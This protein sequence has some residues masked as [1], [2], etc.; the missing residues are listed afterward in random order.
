M[1]EILI[2]AAVDDERAAHA[3]V[4]AGADRLELCG[5]LSV[6]GVTPPPD[7]LARIPAFGVP[8]AVMIRCRGGAFTVSADERRRMVADARAAADAGAAALVL[9]ALDAAGGLDPAPFLAVADAVPGV[10]LV[11]HKAID[12]AADVDAAIDVLLGLPVARV[13]TSGG[14][15]TAWDG[16]ARLAALV[17]RV[18]DRLEILPGGRV[19]ADR[20]AALVRH[21]GVAQLHADGRDASVIAALRAVRYFPA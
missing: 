2:E 18:G 20:A 10:P 17:A 5:D 3:A 16:R 9:G 8:V 7:A 15:A 19:R 14:A 11:C 6:G 12:H 21:T 1:R 4:A 13:L